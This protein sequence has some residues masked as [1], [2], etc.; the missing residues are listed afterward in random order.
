MSLGAVSAPDELRGLVIAASTEFLTL[1]RSFWKYF[2][3]PLTGAL[4]VGPGLPTFAVR[5]SHGLR[6]LSID[7]RPSGWTFLLFEDEISQEAP[8]VVAL[9]EVDA[10]LG[11]PLVSRFGFHAEAVGLAAGLKLMSA[12]D[13]RFAGDWRY[14]LA[15][16]L[17]HLTR[18]LV[19]VG[20]PPIEERRFVAVAPWR[21]RLPVDRIHKG[22]ALDLAF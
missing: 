3:S 12:E 8:V 22:E 16:E 17:A 2:G 20:P 7:G 5:D 14:G 4:K 15:L 1:P 10:R 18:W 6:E 21:H 9:A 19:L 13:E 11:T